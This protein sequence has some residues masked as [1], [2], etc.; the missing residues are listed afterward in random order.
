[1]SLYGAMM[2]G[3]DSLDA[4]SNAMS[5]YSSNIANV[6]T[7]GYKDTSAQFS[8]MLTQMFGG[9]DQAGV[10]TLAAQNNLQQGLL[11]SASSPTD[12]AVSGNGFF[13]VSANQDGSGTPLYTRAGNFST[14]S[15]GYLVNGAGY[16]LQGWPIGA[17][18]SVTTGNTPSPINLTGLSVP[19]AMTT[20][21]SL[22]GNLNSQDTVVTNYNYQTNNMTSGA[23]TPSFSTTFNFTDSKGGTQTATIDFCNTGNNTWAFEVNYSPASNV[24]G[25][26]SGPALLTGGTMTF[27]SD[28]SLQ[29]ITDP[30]GNSETTVPVALNFSGGNTGLANQTFNLNLG[31]PG[32]VGN[33][34]GT[35]GFTDY[36][37][38]DVLTSSK[39]DGQAGGTVSG[40]TIGKDGTVTAQF[41]NGQTKNVFQI[42]LVTF[43][44]ANGLAPVSGDAW[45]AS[46]ASGGAVY[47]APT[48]G[49]AVSIQSGA[50]EGSTVDLATEFTNLITSQRAYSAGARIV[51]T[52][53]QM[54]QTLEQLPSS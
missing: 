34:G 41:S 13:A 36:S 46:T 20:T 3:I 19:P 23:V 48:T 25:T 35:D 30:T 42:P 40:V 32:G 16:Y 43:A 38:N 54:L 45:Q 52:A 21:G 49:A 33:P 14:N 6:N 31:T 7:V 22:V 26:G 27:N 5:I 15:A 29:S 17:N 4:N 8:T 18:G 53:D 9:I 1:M 2:M 12:L 50:L 10:S 44:N 47:N 28:G 51:T 39:F 37:S 24:G 11:Q